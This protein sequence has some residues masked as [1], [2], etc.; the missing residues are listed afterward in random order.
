MRVRY[1]SGT[2]KKN[3]A[4]AKPN[5]AAVAC[6]PHGREKSARWREVA[7]ASR[8]RIARSRGERLWDRA[9]SGDRPRRCAMP[10]LR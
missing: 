6:S 3:V 10:P 1:T 2:R 8:G 4:S 9:R 5:T 7:V